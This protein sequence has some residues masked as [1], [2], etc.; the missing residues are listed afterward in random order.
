MKVVIGFIEHQGKLLITQRALNT[1]FGGYWEFPGG[2]VEL[3]ETEEFAL[4]RELKEE[5]NII[6]QDIKFITSLFDDIE[7]HL[8][9]VTRFE[10]TPITQAGQIG[11]QWLEIAD[12]NNYSF[13]QINIQ[14][15]KVW[16]D[17]L[18]SR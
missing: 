13:P 4:T 8:F 15:F 10:G 16:E 7:F 11:M 1:S 3:G 6:V 14:F 5:L 12:I 9:H 17:Y 2:K 18:K